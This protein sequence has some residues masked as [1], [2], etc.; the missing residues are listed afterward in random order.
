MHASERRGR[1]DQRDARAV[2]PPVE[3]SAQVP[4]IIA[5]S[6][7]RNWLLRRRS[8]KRASA[9]GGRVAVKS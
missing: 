9:A 7:R 1:A 2:G 6:A 5:T 8:G 3:S 4:P